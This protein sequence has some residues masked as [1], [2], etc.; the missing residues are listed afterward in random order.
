VVIAHKPAP[1]PFIV[2]LYFPLLLFVPRLRC[3]VIG[4]AAFVV[5]HCP[6]LGVI[7]C[8]VTFIAH[9]LLVY[10]VVIVVFEHIVVVIYCDCW[11]IRCCWVIVVVDYVMLVMTLF[12]GC[13]IITLGL[14]VRYVGWLS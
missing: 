7:V 1:L 2:P 13:Y 4:V 12:P 9:L 8:N 6:C 10:L 11:L 3:I 14:I 5:P